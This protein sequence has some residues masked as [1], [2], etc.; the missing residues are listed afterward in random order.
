MNIEI[1]QYLNQIIR[2]MTDYVEDDEESEDI[3]I[4][5][6]VRGYEK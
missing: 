1:D 4:N 6:Q 2:D 3:D 5:P